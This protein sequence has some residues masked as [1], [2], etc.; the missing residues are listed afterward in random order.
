MPDRLQELARELLDRE[1][2]RDHP[3]ARHQF[4]LTFR[5]TTYEHQLRE[6]TDLLH[7]VRNEAFAEMA[8]GGAKGGG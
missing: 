6:L 5:S 3:A 1:Y 7:R 4:T 2:G 8:G